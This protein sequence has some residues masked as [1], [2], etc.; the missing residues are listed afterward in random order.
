MN[1]SKRI[2]VLPALATCLLCYAG[3]AFAADVE[4]NKKRGQVYYR[5]VCTVC[6]MQTTGESIPPASRTMAEWRSYFD[7][8]THD[9]TGQSNASVR[10]YTSQAYRETIKDQ[11][12]AARKFL[13]LSDEQIFAD[14]REFAVN[15]AK[16]SD[17]PATCN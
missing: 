9:A 3:S 17:T 6:H 4:A 16:D 11:N 8:D 15:G 5:M 2:L 1:V 12:K 13:T 14:V 10:Y 7:A